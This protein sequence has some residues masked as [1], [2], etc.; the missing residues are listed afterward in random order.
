MKKLYFVS[1]TVNLDVAVGNVVADSPTEAVELLH[2][3]SGKHFKDR[4]RTISCIEEVADIFGTCGISCEPE[5]MFKKSQV[6]N[7]YYNEE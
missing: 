2:D 1:L 7:Y 5:M 3:K 6:L 4:P